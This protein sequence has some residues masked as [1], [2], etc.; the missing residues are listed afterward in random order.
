M[1]VLILNLQMQ[2][3]HS[4]RIKR[5]TRQPRSSK[6]GYC[7]IKVWEKS[8]RYTIRMKSLRFI[9]G[10]YLNEERIRERKKKESEIYMHDCM[11]TYTDTYAHLCVSIHLATA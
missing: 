4:I 6:D 3:R 1:S 8:V 5:S 9:H 10:Q 2:H 7:G 11:Y